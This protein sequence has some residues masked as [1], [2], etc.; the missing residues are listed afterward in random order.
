MILD[1]LVGTIT[2]SDKEI[3]GY[4]EKNKA[5]LPADASEADLKTQAKESLRQQKYSEKSRHLSQ[6]YSKK[7]RSPTSFL[8]NSVLI[9][10]SDPDFA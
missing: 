7:Q 6:G 9:T 1:K 3:A 4:I 10:I 8:S 5:S 2:V